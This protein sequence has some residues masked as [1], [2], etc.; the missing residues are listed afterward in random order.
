[1]QI[2]E[3]TNKLDLFQIVHGVDD[4]RWNHGKL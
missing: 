4:Q 1:M 3:Q 2:F